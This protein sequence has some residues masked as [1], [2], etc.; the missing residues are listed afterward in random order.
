MKHAM[1]RVEAEPI[2][3]FATAQ[4]GI[5]SQGRGGALRPGFRK[6]RPLVAFDWLD[7]TA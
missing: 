5:M 7:I 1:L 2:A 3:A 6:V 4:V